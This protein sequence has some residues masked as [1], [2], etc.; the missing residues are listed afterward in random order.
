MAMLVDKRKR[1]VAYAL[2]YQWQTGSRQQAAPS[3]L[4][5]NESNWDGNQLER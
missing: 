4:E 1:A 5:P 3:G 2:A